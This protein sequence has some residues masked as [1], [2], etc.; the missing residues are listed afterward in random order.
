MTANYV[1]RYFDSSTMC[2][3]MNASYDF[4]FTFVLGEKTALDWLESE[5]RPR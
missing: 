5:T 2:E 4:G 1:D 3:V